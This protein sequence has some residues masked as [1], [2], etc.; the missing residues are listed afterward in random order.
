MHALAMRISVA[1]V[2]LALVISA[3]AE[4]TVLNNFTLIDG[5]GHAPVPGSALIMDN[6]RISWVGPVAELLAPAG[7][8]MID[9]T[10][11]YVM[12]GI[13][14]GHVHL[15]IVKDMVQDSKFQTPAYDEEEL[16]IYAAYGV[17]SVGVYGTDKDF[18]FDMRAQQRAGRPTDARIFTAGQG[19]VYKGGY[20]GIPG[21]NVPVSTP[22][23]AIKAVDEQ[24]AKGVDFIK[25]WIDDEKHV[26]PVKMPYA[27]SKAIIDEAHKHNLKAVAHVYY[28]VDA[29]ELVREG[30]DG[31]AHEIRDQP[32]D[33]EFLN[34]MKSHGTWQT[35]GTLSREFAYSEAILPY[36]L[37]PFF[38]RGVTPGTLEVLRSPARVK[39]VVLDQA[40]V[41][42]IESASPLK[43]N[44]YKGVLF[45]DYARVLREALLNFGAEVKAGIP[46]GMGTDSGPPGRYPGF[47]AHVELEMEVLAGL[48]PMQ[49]IVS[50]TSSNAKWLGANDIG[51]I[52]AGK[53]ADLLVLDADPVAD[54]RNTRR[55][56]SVY[57]AGNSVPTIW[58]TCR[59]RA[60]NTC[61]SGPTTPPPMPY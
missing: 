37:D 24:A 33:Q 45:P 59:G 35:V 3:P 25:F 48:T 38:V 18:V 21:V 42:T 55:I 57:I 53:W 60:A 61:T 40:T 2:L 52:A 47:N 19:I 30:L 14:D 11:K 20:G 44:T 8:K 51:T 13:I 50:A 22:Q 4:V 23:E 43:V 1:A 39:T 36:L 34:L 56:D 15:G 7:A 32:V 54:I 10:G 46:Y 49:A 31:F 58:Q 17:T 5:T 41:P 12:P 26:V 6:G 28:L 27:I 9:L 16:K 29:K